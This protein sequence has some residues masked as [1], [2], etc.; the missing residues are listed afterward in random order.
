MT[1]HCVLENGL[2]LRMR[3]E[4]ARARER[5]V[6]HRVFHM[7]R[8]HAAVVE[9]ELHLP[10]VAVPRSLVQ[11]RAALVVGDVERE[12]GFRQTEADGALE[13]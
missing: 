3:P 8:F 11:C 12:V 7:E 5:L 10:C 4:Q 2:D 13:W 6:P 1:A 9:E